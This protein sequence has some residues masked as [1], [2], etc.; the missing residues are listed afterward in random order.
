MN[1]FDLI[2]QRISDSIAVKQRLLNNEV[3]INT[4]SALADEIVDCLDPNEVI[5]P[6]L[7]VDYIVEKRSK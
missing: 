4:I 6:S 7:F 2:K 5:V 3:L 1:N